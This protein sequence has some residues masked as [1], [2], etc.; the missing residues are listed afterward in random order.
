MDNNNDFNGVWHQGLFMQMHKVGIRNRLKHVI[1]HAYSGITNS[2]LY[3]KK[4][5]GL[6]NNLQSTRPGS[7]CR[8]IFYVMLINPLITAI[9]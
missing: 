3:N 2:V 6:F 8:A 9:R 4:E 1:M 5:S 7:L